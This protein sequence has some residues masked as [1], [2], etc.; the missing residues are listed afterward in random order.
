MRRRRMWPLHFRSGVSISSEDVSQDRA[1]S[2]SNN[3]DISFKLR[4]NSSG[5]VPFVRKIDNLA[6]TSGCSITVRIVFTAA[7]FTAEEVQKTK[8]YWRAEPAAE[9]TRGSQACLLIQ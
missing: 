4:R 7:R 5:C 3:I 2:V 8:K 9:Q 1:T 6:A